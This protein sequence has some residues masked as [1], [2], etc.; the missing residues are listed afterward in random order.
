MLFSV[1]VFLLSFVDLYRIVELSLH[2]IQNL[3]RQH[4]NLKT[5]KTSENLLKEWV[6]LRN[7]QVSGGF[8]SLMVV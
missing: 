8:E 7:K 6:F 1:V 2:L 5:S 3:K 4:R